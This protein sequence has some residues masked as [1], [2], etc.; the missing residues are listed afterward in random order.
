M[1]RTFVINLDKDT[2]RMD[3]MHEQ[4]GRLGISYERQAAV[5]GKSYKPNR[6]EYDAEQAI[7]ATGHS[8]LPGEL[9]C[10]LSHVA[11]YKKVV[12]QQIR[13]TLIFEDDV[14]L[15]SNFKKIV[16]SM[17]QQQQR[18]GFEYLL[19]DYVPVGWPFIKQWFR[20][21]SI[22]IK[23]EYQISFIRG[24]FTFGY[25]LLKVGYI[26]PLSVFEGWRDKR[27]KRNPGAVRFFRPVYFAGAYLVTLEGAK[28]LLS[29]AEPV[30]YTADQ[31]PNRARVLKGL[32][33][34]CYAP[35]SVRQLKSTFGSSIL[36][37]SG[38]DI[39]CN[40]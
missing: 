14:E 26:V 13:Y 15:P 24:V 11:V 23:A 8:L 22:R 3:F 31:L 2:E 25:A 27:M 30:V 36:D 10:A 17:M 28:K 33:F 9:G 4:L 19:F 12:S 35:L 1:F 7:S 29:L 5:Y 18:S 39:E 21:V 37:L 40:T 38:K 20:S 6:D 16:E 32:R 34:F